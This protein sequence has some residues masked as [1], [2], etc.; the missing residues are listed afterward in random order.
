MKTTLVATAT[1]SGGVYILK[2][3]TADGVEPTPAQIEREL[4]QSMRDGFP[5]HITRPEEWPEREPF[6]QAWT[7]DAGT[8]AVDMEKA[9]E[10]HKD[11]LRKVRAP[12]LADLDRKVSSALIA[13]DMTLAR[14][15]E[16]QRQALRDVTDD[17]RIE[18]ATTPD[19]LKAVVPEVLSVEAVK[20]R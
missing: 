20:A 17:P 15:L 13:E 10:I 5:W 7:Y 11:A 4:A 9:V 1:A 12:L 8:I 2:I 6:R 18:A 14:E 19:E 16:A 3:D